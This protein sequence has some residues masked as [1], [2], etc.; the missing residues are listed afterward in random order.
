MV[1]D[2]LNAETIRRI[3]ISALTVEILSVFCLGSWRVHMKLCYFCPV[4]P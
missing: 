4:K 3:V 1:P 2:R